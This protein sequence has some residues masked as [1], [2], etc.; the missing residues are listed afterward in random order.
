MGVEKVAHP[1]SLLGREAAVLQVALPVLE[2]D[3]LMGD[4]DVAH[5]D[6]LAF[7]LE[8]AQVGCHEGQ[9]AKLGSLA[10]F[11]AAAAGKV[12]ADEAEL[13]LGRVKTCFNPPPFHIEFRPAQ[14]GDD[15]AGLVPCVHPNPRVAFFL[16]QMK[17]AAQAGHAIET[18]ID[19]WRLGSDFLDT[20]TIDGRVICPGF[21][22]FLGRGANAI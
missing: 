10:F 1:C 4:V 6:E 20:H 19:V 5:Q 16:R 2:V 7:S 12:A 22:A 11:A 3:G 9:E 17:M 13:A 8:L 18:A 21:E 15:L 14:T